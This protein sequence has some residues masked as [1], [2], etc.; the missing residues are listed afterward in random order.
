MLNELCRI[1]GVSGDEKKVSEFI[2]SRITSENT[3]YKFLKN[4]TLIVYKNKG[5]DVM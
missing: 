2:L 3:E 1:N 5:I 4:G